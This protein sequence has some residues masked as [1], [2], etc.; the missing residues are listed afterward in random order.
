MHYSECPLY[1][2][3]VVSQSI[4]SGSP[5]DEIVSMKPGVFGFSVDL[6]KLISKFSRWWLARH[7]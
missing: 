6:K 2:Q 5:K 1:S 7:G 4:A 3:I